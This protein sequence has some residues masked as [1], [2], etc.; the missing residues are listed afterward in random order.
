VTLI[1]TSVMV[2]HWS[3]C[4]GRSMRCTRVIPSGCRY[5]DNHRASHQCPSEGRYQDDVGKPASR[6]LH[7]GSWR[8]VSAAHLAL[9]LGALAGLRGLWWRGRRPDHLICLLPP[10][11]EIGRISEAQVAQQL[12]APPGGLSGR[13]VPVKPEKGE[14]CPPTHLAAPTVLRRP[15]RAGSA[16]GGAPARAQGPGKVAAGARVEVIDVDTP[17]VWAARRA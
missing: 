8:G 11:A 9:F 6:R 7:G 10:L 12:V 17:G 13:T 1:G 3:R 2:W 14:P 15:A 5:G 4:C 16:R